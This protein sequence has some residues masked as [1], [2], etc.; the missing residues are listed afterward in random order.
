VVA[1]M[2]SRTR[3]GNY[4]AVPGD[5]IRAKGNCDGLEFSKDR[6]SVQ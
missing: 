6:R 2:A 4:R 3:L 5:R 1:A